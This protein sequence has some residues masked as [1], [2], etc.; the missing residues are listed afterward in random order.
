MRWFS[1]RHA[2]CVRAGWRLLL[3]MLIAGAVLAA[4][5]AQG[6][7]MGSAWQA[8][9]WNPPGPAPRSQ[10]GM[11]A[12]GNGHIYLYGGNAGADVL[13]GDFWEY[14]TTSGV[15][16]QLAAGVAPALIEPHLA[17]D[18]QGNVWEFGGIANPGAGHLT[19][20][21]HSF[22]LYEYQPALSTWS[23]RTPL[24]AN[25]GTDWP[26]GREDFGFAYDSQANALVVFAGEGQGDA[27]LNDLW[28][29]S[30]QGGVW[31]S[32]AQ[33]YAGSGGQAI[34][35]REIYNVSADANGHLYL[36]GGA[37]LQA[38]YGAGTNAYA[39]D[40]WRYDD[41]TQTWSLLA[42]VPNGY[43]PAMPLPRH[44]Y[45]Q[46]VDGAGDFDVLGGYLDAPESPPFFS[47]DAYAGYANA[48][49]FEASAVPG[50]YGL[51]DF[52]Q[53]DPATGWHDLSA[54]LGPLANAPMI[55]YA[56]AYDRLTARLYT[57]GGLHLNGDGLL[58]P[59]NGLWSLSDD[60]PV[61]PT[62]TAT[63][64]AP[65]L[66]S[67]SATSTA[68]ATQPPTG[69]PSATATRTVLAFPTTIPTVTA[70]PVPARSDAIPGA[71]VTASVRA[72]PYRLTLKIGVA[73]KLYSPAEI[74]LQHPRRGEQVLRMP[75]IRAMHSTPPTASLALYVYSIANGKTI[76][77]VPVA[78]TI[79]SPAGAV[80]QRVPAAL[81]QGIGEG[82]ADRHF[83]ANVTLPAGSYR[84]LVRVGHLSAVFDIPAHPC[85]AR[86]E[87]S[88]PICPGG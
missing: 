51:S 4:D 3:C 39:N 6:R 25:P 1:R 29:Y 84:V 54:T 41:A 70:T 71:T 9:P 66:P 2:A 12:D 75:V 48:F 20:D 79:T 81:L 63:A 62:A 42:G 23:D 14:D 67:A 55:P 11:A 44:Y 53:F 15:W 40:L 13:L 8:V 30:I 78:M 28:T 43:D 17:T 52:W 86:R 22:G 47:Q 85:S 64:T 24:D 16:Q 59:S 19:P 34:A 35:P 5:G 26:P 37:Y 82:P 7:A 49:Q 87:T 69:T 88:R 58:A 21:G 36:F 38:P 68:T 83:G 60:G 32:V 65:A 76:S 10:Y 57:F 74:G 73:Q 33:R 56:L 72:G 46:T 77:A 50:A 61:T 31:T 80:L 18:A 27:V 45:G